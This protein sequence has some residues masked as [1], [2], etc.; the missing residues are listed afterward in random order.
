[1]HSPSPT[2]IGLIVKATRSCNL[3]CRY[4]GDWRPGSDNAMPFDVLAAVIHAALQDSHHRSVRF[5][6]HG[7]EPTLLPRNYFAKAMALHDEC[8][9]HDR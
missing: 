6:W 2:S 1:M 5:T 4:C 3:R 7:G 8:D 9:L